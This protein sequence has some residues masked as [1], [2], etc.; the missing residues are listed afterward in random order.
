MWGQTMVDLREPTPTK[1]CESA[2]EAHQ[3]AATAGDGEMRAQ[4]LT[5]AVEY[6]VVAEMLERQDRRFHH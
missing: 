5:L 4:A 3:L 2:A 1:L 6:E